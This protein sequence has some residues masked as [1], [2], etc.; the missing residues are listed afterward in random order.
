MTE[1]ISPHSGVAFDLTSLAEEMR[2]DAAYV[3]GGH[4]AR[5]IVR[6]PDLRIVVVAMR[7]GSVIKEHKADD[8]ASIHTLTGAVRLRLPDR[9]V[10]LPTGH[11]LVLERGVPHNVEAIG[12]ST[13]ALTLGRT[14]A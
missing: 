3:R 7:A 5:T 12:E 6:E 10:D 11:L 13:F 9:V 8:T 2:Q 1:P 4:T 14:K